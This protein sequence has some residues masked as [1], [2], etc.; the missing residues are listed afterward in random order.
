MASKPF[1]RTPK[2]SWACRSNCCPK[3]RPMVSFRWVDPRLYNDDLG[4]W[5]GVGPGCFRKR[6]S[7]NLGIVEPAEPAAKAAK[8]RGHDHGEQRNHEVTI[9]RA[10]L[11]GN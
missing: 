10:R 5:E 8:E 1:S 7:R 6:G 11:P 4:S 9:P 3:S 2:A